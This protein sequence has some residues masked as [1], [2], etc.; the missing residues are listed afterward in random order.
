MTLLFVANL[1]AATP[2]NLDTMVAPKE[3][4]NVS[5]TKLSSD[6]HASQFLIYIKKEVPLHIHKHHTEIIYVVSGSGNM[7]LGDKEFEIKQGDTLRIG[8]NTPHGV[9]VTSQQPL[10]VLSIQAPEFKGLDRHLVDKSGG[11][12]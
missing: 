11:N 6:K 10:K 5:V 12:Q 3:L 9:V 7:T 1:L 4:E 8:E 2:L